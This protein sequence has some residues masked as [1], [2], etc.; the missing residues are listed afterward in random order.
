[1]ELLVE[2]LSPMANTE[3]MKCTCIPDNRTTTKQKVF[4]PSGSFGISGNVGANDA[5]PTCGVLVSQALLFLETPA[6]LLALLLNWPKDSELRSTAFEWAFKILG[7]LDLLCLRNVLCTCEGALK[8]GLSSKRA[9]WQGA[10]FAKCTRLIEDPPLGVFVAGSELMAGL[11][12]TSKD[13]PSTYQPLRRLAS[14][15]NIEFFPSL[16]LLL[17]QASFPILKMFAEYLV[18]SLSRMENTLCVLKDPLWPRYFAPLLLVGGAHAPP[19]TQY[20]STNPADAQNGLEGVVKLAVLVCVTLLHSG[21]IGYR[22]DEQGGTKVPKVLERTSS[23]RNL[24]DDSKRSPS[25]RNRLISG[26][27]QQGNPSEPPLSFSGLLLSLMNAIENVALWTQDTVMLL[28]TILLSLIFKLIPALAA[29]RED[30]TSFAW[31]HVFQLSLAVENFIFYSPILDTPLRAMAERNFVHPGTHGGDDLVLARAMVN[32]LTNLRVNSL[33]S[34]MLEDVEAKTRCKHVV[35]RTMEE[36]QFWGKAIE[37]LSVATLGTAKTL[38]K[39]K[40]YRACESA[41]RNRRTKYRQMKK[42][43]LKTEPLVA[44]LHR[45]PAPVPSLETKKFSESE[46][47]S[48]S[49]KGFS[50]PLAEKSFWTRK[51][52]ALFKDKSTKEK[53]KKNREKIL[54]ERKPE[55]DKKVEGWWMKQQS[56]GLVGRDAI[57]KLAALASPKH[58]IET[59]RIS[60]QVAELLGVATSTEPVRAPEYRDLLMAIPTDFKDDMCGKAESDDEE[61]PLLWAQVPP[62]ESKVEDEDA[63]NDETEEFVITDPVKRHT[64]ETGLVEVRCTNCGKGTSSEGFHEVNNLPYCA[65][66]C[67]EAMLCAVCHGPFEIGDSFTRAQF[68]DGVGSAVL[69][70]QFFHKHCFVCAEDKQALPQAADG[71]YP[72]VRFRDKQLFCLDHYNTKFG[73]RCAHC[74]LVIEKTVVHCLERTWHPGHLFCAAGCGNQLNEKKLNIPSTKEWERMTIRKNPLTTSRQRTQV[75]FCEICYCRDVLDACKGCSK[76]FQLGEEAAVLADGSQFV[77]YHFS[78]VRC[79]CCLKQTRAQMDGN[80]VTLHEGVLLCAMHA[81]VHERG[82]LPSFC[83]RCHLA[84]VG[85]EYSVGGSRYHE[86]CLQCSAC[87]T[88]LDPE[89]YTE[90]KLGHLLCPKHA[91]SQSSGFNCGKCFEP[92]VS[93]IVFELEGARYHHTCLVCRVCNVALG[94]A[95]DRIVRMTPPTA[96]AHLLHS[97]W[98]ET[99]FA[100]QFGTK[101]VA[102]GEGIIGTVIM[103][104]DLPRHQHCIVCQVCKV[105]LTPETIAEH[106]GI[107]YCLTHYGMDPKP[108]ADAVVASAPKKDAP[109]DRLVANA[110]RRPPPSK[111]KPSPTQPSTS[112]SVPDT[113]SPQRA[114]QTATSPTAATPPLAS[115]HSPSHTRTPSS[116]ASSRVNTHTAVGPTASSQSPISR[117]P[118]L[119]RLPSLDLLEGAPSPTSP[120]PVPKTNEPPK[121]APPA[122]P[123]QQ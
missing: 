110:P 73:E 95:A 34:D 108:R 84:I 86:D 69:L 14:F 91:A 21:F 29:F 93:G 33:S 120:Q 40:E 66:C 42:N 103:F 119:V 56:P 100:N 5:T 8:L 47:L 113:S 81:L 117:K 101:C 55:E 61:D 52:E 104:R 25:S 3:T 78:C 51:K 122:R 121:R 36:L 18:Q 45:T 57:P 62:S 109:A 53:R 4:I 76:T 92:I 79:V 39:T 88:P 23:F 11:A 114:Q 64:P 87:S 43:N 26:K 112:T 20:H 58:N 99:H 27:Q 116:P 12:Q 6:T 7:I 96:P 75:G 32:F 44:A 28:R 49:A 38:T 60:M 97:F 10:G 48:N 72:D 83:A 13:R 80:G 2:V 118:D 9:W 115:S 22:D 74:S 17:Q 102:C 37:F 111:P 82:E 59:A 77:C 24:N 46:L 50:S 16:A 30:A 106:D 85:G 1:M 41:L 19:N 65:A 94:N 105:G 35:K 89:L 107:L 70:E 54:D 71:S 67:R 90:G 31:E 98:C 123:R 68:P 15:R 63:S